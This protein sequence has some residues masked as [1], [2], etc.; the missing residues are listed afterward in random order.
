MSDFD[1]L[2]E[3]L[4]YPPEEADKMI[5]RMKIQKLKELKLQVMAQNPTILGVGAPA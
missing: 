3:L 1:I 4:R 5:A 2:T